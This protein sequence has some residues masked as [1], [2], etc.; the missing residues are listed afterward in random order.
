MKFEKIFKEN[1]KETLFTSEA[2][3]STLLRSIK[4]TMDDGSVMSTNVSA[5]AT[6][7]M[8]KAYYKKGAFFNLGVGSK[9]KMV[10]IRSVE[11]LG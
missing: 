10:K 4:V 5:D 7:Q 8:I 11:I 1:V 2:K 9:D 6:D 3:K